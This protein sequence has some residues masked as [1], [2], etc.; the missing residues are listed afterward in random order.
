MKSKT[1]I[2]LLNGNM[3]GII[4]TAAGIDL[5]VSSS[6]TD[7]VLEYDGTTGEFVAPLVSAG[8]GGLKF[9]GGLAFGPKGNLFV[10]SGGGNEVLEY[11]GT[12]GALIT[13]LLTNGSGG[14]SVSSGPAFGPQG[15]LLVTHHAYQ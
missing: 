9:P 14:L 12:N 2:F 4:V 7:Q 3:D 10:A 1:T 8:S 13:A 15:G 6:G 5:F 11:N